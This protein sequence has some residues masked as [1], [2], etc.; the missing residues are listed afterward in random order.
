MREI[1]DSPITNSSL[2][3]QDSENDHNL[4]IFLE[5]WTE[6]KKGTIPEFRLVSTA[7]E[8]LLE[9]MAFSF[10]KERF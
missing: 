8:D 3:I 2:E 6:K 10:D 9:I 4:D 5:E 7:L 1:L